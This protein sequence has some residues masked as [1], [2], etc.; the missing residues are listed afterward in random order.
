MNHDKT[1]GNNFETDDRQKKQ[2]PKC[3]DCKQLINAEKRTRPHK[4]LVRTGNDT[5]ISGMMGS[6]HEVEYHC[7]VCGNIWSHETGD[8]GEGWLQHGPTS[9]D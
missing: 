1:N 5:S 8:L 2:P 3:D 4:H 7:E 6:A 9:E